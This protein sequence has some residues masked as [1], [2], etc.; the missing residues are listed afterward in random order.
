MKFM[1]YIDTNYALFDFIRFIYE[2][3]RITIFYK[4]IGPY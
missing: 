4:I 2:L 1:N 3:I